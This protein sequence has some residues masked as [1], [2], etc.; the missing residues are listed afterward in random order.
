MIL[1]ND[2]LENLVIDYSLALAVWN[3]QHHKPDTATNWFNAEQL[4]AKE[5]ALPTPAHSAQEMTRVL[6]NYL[7]RLVMSTTRGDFWTDTFKEKPLTLSQ[8]TK[9]I[10]VYATVENATDRLLRPIEYR[11]QPALLRGDL[12]ALLAQGVVGLIRMG[13]PKLV[14]DGS[15]YSDES[16][17]IRI[18]GDTPYTLEQR[19]KGRKFELTS[20][21]GMHYKDSNL[22]RT[23][24]MLLDLKRAQNS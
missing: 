8:N 5:Q 12:L 6:D 14:L 10:T 22:G 20:S 16:G 9:S 24:V 21:D 23:G 1:T 2:E 19:F 7:R 13:P 15:D 17:T 4:A 11:Y 3:R 18:T